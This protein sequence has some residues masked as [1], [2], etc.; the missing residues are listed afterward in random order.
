MRKLSTLLVIAMVG[1]SCASGVNVEQ[2]KASLMAADTEWS[3]STKDVNKFAATFAPDAV[4]HMNGAPALKGEKSIRDA[5]TAMSAA[6]GFNLKWQAATAD[7]SGDMG[8][9]TGTY[10]MAMTNAAG[11]P[12]TDKGK[13]V[14]VWKKVNGAWKVVADTPTSDAPAPLSSAAVVVPAGD[15]KWGDAPPVLPA[16][17]KLAV[18]SGDPGKAEP[19]TLRLQM[20]AGY[21]IA[22]HSHPTDE[23]VTVL[24]GTLAAAMGNAFDAKA[25][26]DLAT[27]SYANMAAGMN[28]YVQARTATVVQVHGMGPFV[29][30]YV[31]AA[32]DPSKK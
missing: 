11:L 4:M 19:F 8:F 14:T 2:E 13:Y 24:S 29:V 30:N 16:G 27:G 31:N 23:H 21:K 9:T 18:V 12:A 1:S 6:P 17:A 32:D 10:E 20:P 15:V 5:Y 26:K 25:L 22:P 7:V 28:H 3:T